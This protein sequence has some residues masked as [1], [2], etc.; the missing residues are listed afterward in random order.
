ML[1][2]NLKPLMIWQLKNKYHNK[3]RQNYRQNLTLHRLKTNLQIKL[4][5][6]YGKPFLTILARN[7]LKSNEHGLQKKKQAV[8]LRLPKHQLTN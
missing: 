1:S 4:L 2:N 3:K 6:K 5:M 7:L 8:I